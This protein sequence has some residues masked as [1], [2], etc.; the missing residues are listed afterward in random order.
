MIIRKGIKNVHLV[1]EEKVK[2]RTVKLALKILYTILKC[3]CNV[4]L[5]KG[6]KNSKLY[7]LLQR[8]VNLHTNYVCAPFTVTIST[9]GQTCR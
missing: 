5:N 4:M 2:R 8:R 7:L 6:R 3:Y 1:V 9:P